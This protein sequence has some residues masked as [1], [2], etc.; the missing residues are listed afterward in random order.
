MAIY[1]TRMKKNEQKLKIMKIAMKYS[2]P[3]GFSLESCKGK[4]TAD[5]EK[6]LIPF[7]LPRKY[8]MSNMGIMD[9]TTPT[10]QTHRQTI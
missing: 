4:Q 2:Q 3:E 5:C 6:K 7:E 9:K 8:S 10:T 1:A